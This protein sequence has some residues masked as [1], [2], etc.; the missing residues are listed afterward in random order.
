MEK[1][2]V[3]T[4][5]DETIHVSLKSLATEQERTISFLIRKAVEAY[6]QAN[7]VEQAQATEK[8]NG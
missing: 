7:D 3:A 1:V 4:R 6:V 5:I 8:D 2:L